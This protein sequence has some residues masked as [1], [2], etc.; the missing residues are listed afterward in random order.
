MAEHEISIL[1]PGMDHLKTEEGVKRFNEAVEQR[2][3]ADYT[4]FLALRDLADQGL[5]TRDAIYRTLLAD[6]ESLAEANE[7]ARELADMVADALEARKKADAEFADA[8]MGR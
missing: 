6:G 7:G 2:N 3:Q 5:L 1:G 8:L 4:C